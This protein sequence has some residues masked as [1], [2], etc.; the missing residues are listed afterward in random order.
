MLEDSEREA[1]LQGIAVIRGSASEATAD[2]R[3]QVVAKLGG[4][5]PQEL[6][7]LGVTVAER[8]FWADQV[9]HL[10]LHRSMQSRAHNEH[11]EWRAAS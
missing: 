2:Q 7:K 1:L 8:T 9:V 10:L 11:A 4:M 5:S 6:S 3:I